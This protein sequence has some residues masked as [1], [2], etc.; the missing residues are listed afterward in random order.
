MYAW[1][2]YI[3]FC[4]FE[5]VSYVPLHE[6]GRQEHEVIIIAHY[7]QVMVSDRSNFADKG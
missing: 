1:I 2:F 6:F 4:T 5:M 7:E 3:I